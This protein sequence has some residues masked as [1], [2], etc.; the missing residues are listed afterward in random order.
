MMVMI[1]M[2]IVVLALLLTSSPIEGWSTTTGE[3]WRN[4]GGGDGG[5]SAHIVA[6]IPNIHE[7]GLLEPTWW[8]MW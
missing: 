8:W 2:L 4:C 3:A 6:I 7:R 1:R 5:G